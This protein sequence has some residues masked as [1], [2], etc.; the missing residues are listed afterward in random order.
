LAEDSGATKLLNKMELAEILAPAIFSWFYRIT[1]TARK[2]K[3]RTGEERR[4]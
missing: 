4:R 3:E 2:L 1:K